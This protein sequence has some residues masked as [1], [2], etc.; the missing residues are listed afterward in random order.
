VILVLLAIGLV[1][2]GAKAPLTAWFGRAPR[3]IHV[4]S[5]WA[6]GYVAMPQSASPPPK[7]RKAEGDR[8]ALLA[9]RRGLAIVAAGDA[10][11]VVVVDKEGGRR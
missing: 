9:R 8:A 2:F 3:V 6:R 5:D 1:W 4:G 10:G 11:E 7:T